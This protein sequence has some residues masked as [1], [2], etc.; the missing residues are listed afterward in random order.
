MRVQIGYDGSVSA[1]AVLADL[2]T[3]GL[4]RQEEALI[5]SVSEVVMPPSLIGSVV[6]GMP[7]ALHDE[8]WGV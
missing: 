4:P 1:D 6:V 7:V 5:V 3:A 8:Y 2:Q